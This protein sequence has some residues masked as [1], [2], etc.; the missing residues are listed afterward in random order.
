MPNSYI[1]PEYPYQHSS[2]QDAE[3]PVHHPV[4]IVGGGP[5]GL[6]A[7]MDLSM[8]GI[9]SLVLDDN[10]T[11]SVGSRAICIAKRT[12]EICDRY[13]CGQPMLDKG[14]TWN[15]GKVY[16]GEEQVYEFNLLPEQDHR[17]P[18]FINLQQYYMEEYMVK[19]CMELPEIEL[20]WL[21][22]VSQVSTDD[23][24][25]KVTVHT[26]EGDYALTCDYLL[27]A[28]GANS[29]IRSSLGLES[30]GQVF[31]DRFLIADIIMKADFPAERR[32]WFD[33]PFHPDQS[34]LLHKQ[35]DNVWRIDFQLG[36]DADPE[37]EKKLENI[38]PRVEAMLGKDMAWE[39]DWASVYTFRCRKMDSFIHHR[40]FFIGDSAHQ[41]SP[42]GARGAN[43]AL[44]SVENLGWKLAAVIHGRAPQ[45]LLATYDI[46]RQHGAREN[47]LNSTRATDFMTPKNHIT[48]VFRDTVLDL[49]R[50][51]P[52]ARALVNSG[53]LSKPCH[54]PQSP[55]SSS[56]SDG[57]DGGVEPGHSC[58]D[59]PVTGGNDSGWLLNHIGNRFNLLVKGQVDPEAVE[60]IESAVKASGQLLDWVCVDDAEHSVPQALQLGDE[61]GVLNERYNL[62]EAAVYLIR[63]DQH[64]AARWRTLDPAA[65]NAALRRALGFAAEMEQAA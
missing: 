19:R 45:S 59:A 58:P 10:N 65:V 35:A 57:F 37:E 3:H 5:A 54:Y 14:V 12:L 27:V 15:L 21:H 2:D 40:V 49:S 17:M 48:K 32:F 51:Y 31:E 60:A 29:P 43:G 64:V 38:R 44:Q 62:G 61:K 39:L 36:W 18:A 11:V 53:R 50:H 9:K 52:F 20:R 8:Q 6:A 46:E 7:A 28:D 24:G 30:K 1:N 63:P 22:K 41:V 23:K 56:D 34:T 25:A 13:G 26:S 16:F 4:I 33:A 55:L 47:I 42:F